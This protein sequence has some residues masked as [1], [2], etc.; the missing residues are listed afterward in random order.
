MATTGWFVPGDEDPQRSGPGAEAV[1]DLE[2]EAG[3][4]SAPVPDAGGTSHI[5]AFA[6]LLLSTIYAY[7]YVLTD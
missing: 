1:E 7:C 3:G 6:P 4:S 2:S 5:Y